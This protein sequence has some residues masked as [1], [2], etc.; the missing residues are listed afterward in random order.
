V[1]EFTA[2]ELKAL[3][4]PV[5][6]EEQ[7]QPDL[8]PEELKALGLEV[9]EEPRNIP[10]TSAK[11]TF[12]LR[13]AGAIPA[14]G[15][16]ADILATGALK[17]ALTTGKNFPETSRAISGW[18]GRNLP[19]ALQL[20]PVAGP[21]ATLTPQAQAELAR[22]GEASPEEPPREGLIDT[23]R[24]MRDTRRLRTAA[25]S[26]EHPWA[27]RAGAVT[28]T[29]ASVLAPLPSV[30]VNPS[31]LRLIPSAAA[32]ERVARIASGA[33][34]GGA[35]GAFNGLTDGQADL[36][37]G[38][39]GKAAE[40]TANAAAGGALFGGA[41]A[42]AAEALRPMAGRLRE[43]AVRQGRRVIGGDSDMAAQSRKWLSDE[44]VLQALEDRMIRPFSTTEATYRRLDQAASGLGEEYG[45]ILQRLDELGVQ[46]PRATQL[47]S[48]FMRRA[49]E[50]R[51]TMAAGN[52]AP[53]A[54]AREARN[55]AAHGQGTQR[56]PLLTAESLKRDFQRMGRHER[57][58]NSPNEET[59]QELGSRMR[60]A[61]EDE[62]AMAGAAGGAGSEVAGLAARFQ[63]LKARLSNT[64]AARNV[65]EKG[66][67]K[68]LQKS[69]VGLKDMLLGAAAGDPG[70]AAL[71]ALASSGVRNRLPSASA[72]GTY[73]LSEGL[74]TGSL[75]PELAK[76]ITL[77]ADPNITDTTQAL[78]E[79]L[80]KKKENP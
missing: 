24:E 49:N 43:A 75:S 48:E 59:Y 12:A 44:A 14:G 69:P 70:T 65:G 9:P 80:R 73:A 7:P 66:A 25:G 6:G 63:P 54:M 79:A 39:V 74:R 11:A 19:Q 68:A 78:V 38:E 58:N 5:P 21:G 26:K 30:R 36:T 60:Q 33:A 3:G 28:G 37:R 34:T 31:A 47:A 41:A 52:T 45:Q 57:L 76:L 35:Y 10:D 15:L 18:V 67:S 46:G 55:L 20:S 61:I 40:E 17:S 27:G 23:Y 29:V 42:G 2:E 51:G 13:G 16:I 77:A 22:M 72:A 8:T 1:A 56:L 4:L 53:R 64:I 62:V 32:A 71:T 50:M